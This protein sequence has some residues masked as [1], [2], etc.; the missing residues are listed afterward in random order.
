MYPRSKGYKYSH[1]AFVAAR[2]KE[3]GEF[4]YVGANIRA[5]KENWIGDEM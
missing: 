5:D 2:V 1:L 4:D 3:D